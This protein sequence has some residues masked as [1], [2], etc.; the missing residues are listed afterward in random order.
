MPMEGDTPMKS[1]LILCTFILS[2]LTYASDIQSFIFDGSEVVKSTTLTDSV[3]R[4]EYRYEQHPAICYR[5]VVIGQTTSCQNVQVGET[6][7]TVNGH[8]VCR[9]V[10]SQQCRQVPVY[11]RQAF[12]C[13]QSVRVSYQVLDHYSQANVQLSF[14]DVPE[15][16]LPQ[17]K[18]TLILND[19]YLT[20]RVKS[21]GRVAMFYT[22]QEYNRMEGRNVIKNVQYKIKMI[23]L[24]KALLPAQDKIKL[25]S[26]TADELIVEVG[27]IPQDMNYLYQLKLTKVRFLRKDPVLFNAMVANNAMEFEALNGR[28]LIHIKLDKLNSVLSDGKYKADFSMSPTLPIGTLLN[29]DIPDL[30][31]K[32]KKKFKIK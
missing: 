25:I 17:E 26:S 3:Y 4:T 32:M 14:Y 12:T 27:D 20:T 8:R 21:S 11:G 29:T 1:L 19:D 31:F 16:V 6:C 28:T 10:Y 18:I 22:K 9:P 7:N 24:Q 23:D 13:Y 30:M 5:T 15:N 2:T